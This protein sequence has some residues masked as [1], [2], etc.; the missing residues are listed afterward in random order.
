MQE[1]NHR[2]YM[3]LKL[4]NLFSAIFLIT[5]MLCIANSI[6]DQQLVDLAKQCSSKVKA[7]KT[8]PECKKVIFDTMGQLNDS[9]KTR[10]I[11]LRMFEFDRNDG[12]LQYNT[13][14]VVM[15]IFYYDPL[16]ITDSLSLKELM[17]RETDA[18]RFY[19]L[20]SIANQLMDTQKADF[21][22]ETAP[23]LF[24]HEPLAKMVGEYHFENL[25]DASYNSYRMIIKNLNLLNAGFT[26]PDEKLPYPDKISILVKWLRANYPGCENL[27]EK[28][29]NLQ[30]LKGVNAA[31][32]A[33]WKEKQISVP[34][35]DQSSKQALSCGPWWQIIAAATVLIMVLGIWF[36]LKSHS[37]S[38]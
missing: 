38:L 24:R 37:G 33:V 34:N 12:R 31:E 21:V 17:M 6:S 18:R 5:S 35:G 30:E 3:N 36:K 9:E 14:G 27:G 28:T 11:A 2:K 20:S 7:A 32:R 4:F 25:S 19:L 10:A 13:A 15:Q 26:P 29:E 16:F 1:I 23:M 8:E 22:V